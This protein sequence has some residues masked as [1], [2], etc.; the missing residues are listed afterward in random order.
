MAGYGTDAGLTAWLAANGYTLPESAPAPAILRQRAS[1]YIDGLYEARFIGLRTD[2][3]TQ[4]RAWPRTGA[5]AQGVAIPTDAIPGA[6]ERAA[7]AASLHEANNPGSLSVGISASAAVKREKVD[8]LETEYFAGS[9]DVVADATVRLS[10]V[11]GLLAPFLRPETATG[12]FLW[13]V[14]GP[15]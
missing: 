11:D 12:P 1:D 10:V 14:G 13:A 2:P 4:E 3:L 9:G 7:Y 15:T 5:V 6:V 8:V